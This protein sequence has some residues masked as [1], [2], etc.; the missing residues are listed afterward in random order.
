MQIETPEEKEDGPWS[1]I[2][3]GLLILAFSVWMYS[4]FTNM[5]Q[6][7]GSMRIQWIFALL[8]NLLGKWGVGSG[9]SA[10][11]RGDYAR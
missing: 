4:V 3:I 9:A 7:G 1:L 5:E 10:R 6:S 2:I 11:M 8:Y